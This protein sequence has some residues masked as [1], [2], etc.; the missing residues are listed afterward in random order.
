MQL[1]YEDLS[2][3]LGGALSG[4]FR[5]LDI[6]GL[7][8]LDGMFCAPGTVRLTRINHTVSG[9]P[10]RFKCGDLT[11]K[12]DM[13]WKGRMRRSQKLVTTFLTLP[14]LLRYGYI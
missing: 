14:L 6:S 7:K 8:P 5:R 2:T 11:V 3:D 1:R 9:N 13:E 12:P 10:M 4:I